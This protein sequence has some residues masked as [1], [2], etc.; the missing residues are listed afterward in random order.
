MI[1]RKIIIIIQGGQIPFF[2]IW[3]DKVIMIRNRRKSLN[4]T[5][6]RQNIIIITLSRVKN[7]AE[8]FG[9]AIAE[10]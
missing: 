8:D 6:K 4:I 10:N 3:D 2:E 9:G 5:A 1:Y 7:V